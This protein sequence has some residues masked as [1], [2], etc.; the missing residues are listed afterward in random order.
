MGRVVELF[1]KE[2]PKREIEIMLCVSC[3]G[4]DFHIIACSG[5]RIICSD[6]E[7]EV[8]DKRWVKKRK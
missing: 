6:C 5:Q 7:T 1:K 8:L 3:T 2:P 4:E